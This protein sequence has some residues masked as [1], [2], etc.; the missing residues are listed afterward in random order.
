MGGDLSTA[1][2]SDE[3]E[4]Y[5]NNIKKTNQGLKKNR[6]NK[7]LKSKVKTTEETK[8][9]NRFNMLD[10]DVSDNE[11]FIKKIKNKSNKINE[12]CDK[13]DNKDGVSSMLLEEDC[14]ISDELYK[15]LNDRNFMPINMNMSNYW[16]YHSYKSNIDFQFILCKKVEDENF[17]EKTEIIYEDNNYDEYFVFVGY[18]NITFINSVIN[19]NNHNVH[20]NYPRFCCSFEYNDRYL[21][22]NDF[23]MI[24]FSYFKVY[25]CSIENKPDFDDEENN[26]ENDD[27]D[28]DEENNEENDDEDDDEENDEEEN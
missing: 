10:I 27:E 14:V 1:F 23:H 25:E 11:N 17:K 20:K 21:R 4:I 22:L 5:T 12:D 9:Y 6:Q 19:V 15:T 28:D 16:G 7:K 3:N 2:I 8:L 18:D 13:N 24:I 26:E